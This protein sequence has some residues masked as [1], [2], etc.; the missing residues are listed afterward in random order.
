[1]KGRVFRVI[2]VCLKKVDIAGWTRFA[3][4]L[5]DVQP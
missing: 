5:L 2:F 1:M 3:M 4:L